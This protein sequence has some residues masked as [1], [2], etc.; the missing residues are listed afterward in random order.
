MKLDDQFGTRRPS[1]IDLR[2]GAT[3]A[4][5]VA[6]LRDGD[7][8]PAARKALSDLHTDKLA[9]DLARSIASGPVDLSGMRDALGRPLTPSTSAGPQLPAPHPDA[10]LDQLV[11]AT[12]AALTEPAHPARSLAL[13]EQVITDPYAVAARN[14]IAAFGLTESISL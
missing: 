10:V 8:P 13:D 11:T 12:A 6:D 7:L 3:A 9:G 14:I 2:R 1:V 4:P 5:H